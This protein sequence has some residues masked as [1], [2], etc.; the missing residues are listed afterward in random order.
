MQWWKIKP[1]RFFILT[2][3]IFGSLMLVLTP[4]FQVPDEVNHF[5]RAY[6]IVDGGFKAEQYQFRLGGEVPRSL[7]KVA[8]PFLELRWQM[9]RKTTFSAISK[10]MSI[11]LEPDNTTFI[12]F[13]NTA[14]YNPVS[15]LPQILPIFILKQLNAP[16]LLIFY[17]TR[18]FT[19]AVWVVCI[20]FLIRSLVA[21]KWLFT[22]LAL[23]PMTVY[24]SMGVSA[25]VM[26]NL[27]AFLF[28]GF[29]LNQRA[30]TKALGRQEF[31][32][33]VL[34]VFLL[35]SAK[36]VYIALVFL[37]L[38]IPS[39]RFDRSWKFWL[40][41]AGLLFLGLT[42]SFLWAGAIS[43]IYLPY[44]QYNL[45]FRDFLDLPRCANMHEQLNYILGHG[46]YVVEVF[47]R[48][49][50]HAFSM[51]YPGYIGTFG[52]LDAKMPEWLIHL[53]YMYLFLITIFQPPTKFDFT[54]I[55]RIILFGAAIFT[56]AA[57]LLS[58]LLSWECVGGDFI[59]TIQG[60]YFIPIFPLLFL[61][62]SALIKLPSYGPFIKNRLIVFYSLFLLSVSSL[63]IYKRYFI[64][65]QYDEIEIKCDAEKIQNNKLVTNHP[66]IFIDNADRRSDEASRSG[67][68]S[69]KI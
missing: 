44:D 26:T 47:F 18:I 34:F 40:S 31:L 20:G 41:F 48:S 55:D 51:Y 64:T 27:V 65:S 32:K 50:Y 57:L 69:L 9:N 4:P 49:L 52:W 1:H 11:P 19:L 35:A 14:L 25:D 38:L 59:K 39:G 2:G 56:T 21:F 28:V 37:F 63:V 22:M 13:P 45:A 15:Y 7:I 6:Q 16:P 30:K 54:L 58:Q 10:Q 66:G 67:E 60:R 42:T 53:T 33:M 8:D 62:I 24:M 12:D 29:I 43:Q 68:Y 23:L 17:G 61:S 46:V 36:V 5:Y 3:A